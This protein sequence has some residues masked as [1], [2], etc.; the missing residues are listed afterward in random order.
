MRREMEKGGDLPS[1][2]A[3]LTLVDIF[4]I[5]DESPDL[6]RVAGKAVLRTFWVEESSVWGED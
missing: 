6:Y 5:Q 3:G 2:D 4:F 1:A